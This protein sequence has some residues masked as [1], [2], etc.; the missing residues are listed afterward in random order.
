MDA[1]EKLAAQPFRADIGRCF[2][3]NCFLIV[4]PG[5]FWRFALL[6]SATSSAFF[7]TID[8]INNRVQPERHPLLVYP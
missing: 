4:A 8:G 5:A 3:V 1:V 7:N 2:K 6:V